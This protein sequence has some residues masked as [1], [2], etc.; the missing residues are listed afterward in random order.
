MVKDIA[1][2]TGKI[3]EPIDLLE[4]KKE[5]DLYYAARYFQF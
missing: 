4:M 1:T 3:D 5:R 2:M